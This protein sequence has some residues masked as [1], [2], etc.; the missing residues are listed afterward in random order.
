MPSRL[1]YWCSIATL[2]ALGVA[3]APQVFAQ[4]AERSEWHRGTALSLFAGA[5]ST[6]SDTRVA[7]GAALEWE[8]TPRLT[9]EGSGVWADE[10][11]GA[12]SFGGVLGSRV[13][14][15]P[16]RTVVPFAAGGIG[17][18][19]ASF[20]A[21][22]SAMPDFYHHRMPRSA[23]PR[24]EFTD[25]AFAIGGGVDVFLH[26]HLALRPDVRVLLVTADSRLRPV[27]VV[28]VHLAYHFE[29]HNVTPMRRGQR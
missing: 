26:R 27:T 19:R 22:T 21:D 25:L 12:T 28:G 23:G 15:L 14:L 3:A 18:Y 8:L 6:S 16:R 11:S 1:R 17:L 20:G 7:A 29:S 24:R 10:P 4:E 9:I 2:L 13:N 5:A